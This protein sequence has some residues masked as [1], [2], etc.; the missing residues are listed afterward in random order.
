MNMSMMM[1]QTSYDN[2][3]DNLKLNNLEMLVN[4]YGQTLM[5]IKQQ[6][7]NQIVEHQRELN[8]ITM[9]YERKMQNLINEHN[10]LKR[11][12]NISLM[13]PNVDIDNN[14]DMK[15]NLYSNPQNINDLN[16]RFSTLKQKISEI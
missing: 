9:D 14:D 8:D 1:N 12:V 4:N 10:E 2:N 11:K 16:N 13:S 3:K 6:H 15:Y 5:A 7:E